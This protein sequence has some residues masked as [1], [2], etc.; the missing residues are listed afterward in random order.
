MTREFVKMFEK[1]KKS[2][3][4]CC[5]CCKAGGRGGPSTRTWCGQKSHV[6]PLPSWASQAI[7]SIANVQLIG[8]GTH[9]STRTGSLGSGSQWMGRCIGTGMLMPLCQ[10]PLP[11]RI[12]WRSEARL[13][14]EPLNSNWRRQ[15]DVFMA[16]TRGSRAAFEIRSQWWAIN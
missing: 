3:C 15:P 12:Y 9:L 8:N 16:L 13:Q 7:I 5:S 11:S 14:L 1:L 6:P 10:C 2:R 4:R